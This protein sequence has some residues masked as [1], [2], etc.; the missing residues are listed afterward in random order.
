M[1]EGHVNSKWL[2]VT[3]VVMIPVNSYSH[4]R[5]C[6][7]SAHGLRVWH[8]IQFKCEGPVRWL[9]Q[10]L[11]VPHSKCHLWRKSIPPQESTTHLIDRDGEGHY[12]WYLLKRVRGREA[13]REA[14]MAARNYV[15]VYVRAVCVKK[16]NQTVEE[17]WK[18]EKGKGKRREDISLRMSFMHSDVFII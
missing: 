15:W 13:E 16:L 5:S 14:V 6:N 11:S 17:R 1:T 4:R 18:L 10:W 12:G 9:R 8:L 3:V 2:L 7:G